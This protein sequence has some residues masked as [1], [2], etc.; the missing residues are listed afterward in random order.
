M[1]AIPADLK[2]KYKAAGQDHVFKYADAGSLDEKQV[3]ALVEQLQG[4]DLDRIAAVHNLAMEQDSKKADPSF[5]PLDAVASIAGASEEERKS[6]EEAGL[7][8]IKAGEVAACTLAGG[9]GTRLGFPKPKGLFDIKLPSGKTLFHLFADRLKKLQHMA[10]ATSAI[11]WYIMTSEGD[12]HKETTQYF[13]DEDYF[14]Y[15]EKDIVFFPQGTLPCLTEEGKLMLETG[16]KVGAAADGNGGIYG[17]LKTKQWGLSGESA[18]D[19]MEKRGVKYMHAF[20]VDNAIGKV[21]DPLFVGYCVKQGA[22]VGNKVV[23]KNAPGEKVGVLGKNQGKYAVIEYSEIGEMTNEKGEKL[24]EQT[25]KDGKLLFG[26]GNICNHFYTTEF[27][28]QVTDDNLIFHVARKKIKTPSE[29]GKTAV[30]ATKENG[31]KLEAFIFDCFGMAQNMAVLEGGRSSEFSPVKNKD[32]EKT[33][34]PQSAR[35]MLTEQSV[36]W[37]KAAGYEVTDGPGQVEITPYVSY[38]GEGLEALKAQLADFYGDGPI[39]R[40]K[41]DILIMS[42]EA[43]GAPKVMVLGRED[44]TERAPCSGCVTM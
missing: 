34:T 10:G 32:G 31:I 9:A 41:G 22:D 13:K 5:T 28:K 14:G 16:C 26:A 11:P 38:R 25:D 20:S 1:S 6:W 4:L 19:N 15:D 17:A 24:V 42:D 3:Q 36:E 39:D 23:W 43:G 12:N 8:A 21:A 2:E 18:L 35:D 33:D 40:T 37:L 44:C 30:E 27:L 29:D 7:A